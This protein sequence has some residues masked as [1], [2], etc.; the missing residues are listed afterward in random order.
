[1]TENGLVSKY[2]VFSRFV[3]ALTSDYEEINL[4]LALASLFS[5]QAC[6]QNDAKTGQK[7]EIQ[8]LKDFFKD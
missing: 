5:F 4:L 1:M 6:Q 8:P 7:A 3:S 2:P